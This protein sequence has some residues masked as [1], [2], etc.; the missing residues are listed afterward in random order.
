MA[1]A[2]KRTSRAPAGSS[3][4]GRER[5]PRSPF[6]LAAAAALLFLLGTAEERLFGLVTDESQVLSTAVA[7]A[8]QGEIGIARG[9]RFTVP[10][11]EGDAVSPYGM[12][13][14]LVEVPAVLLAP[15]WESTFGSGTSQ[16]VFVALAA[17]LVWGAGLGAGLLAR[18]LGAGE[19][20]A[21]F[22]LLATAVGSP[23]AAYAGTGYSEPLQALCL[24][25]T[26]LLA[27]R[28]AEDGAPRLAAAA[29]FAAG[30]AV[31]T[32]SVNL[33]IAPLALL[34]LLVGGSSASRDRLRSAAG[35][36]AGAAVPLGAWL[37]FEVA[38]FGRPL[39]SYAGQS[40][41]HSVPDGLWRLLVG[42]NKG[43][44]LYFPLLAAALAGLVALGSRRETRGAAAATAGV[45]G[46]LL[47][48]SS[49]W[50]AWDGTVGWGPRF[51][52]PAVP[53][54][55]A[56]AASW[57]PG[58]RAGRAIVLALGAAGLLVN[59]LGVFE[60]D[61]A[62]GIYLAS[63]GRVP[64]TDDLRRRIPSYYFVPDANGALS[65]PRN[66]VAA[67]DAA[68][69]PIRM[70]AFLLRARLAGANATDIR[71]R[72]GRPPWAES[73]PDAL[74]SL[75]RTGGTLSNA[76][77]YDAYLTEPF[78]WPGVGAVAREASDRRLAR[79]A[80]A[81][82]TALLGQALRNLAIGRPDRA[83]RFATRL[84]ES[85]PFAL[86]AAL[87]AES[88]RTAGR[89][90]EARAFLDGLDRRYAGAGVLA[91]ERALLARD[92][93]DAA[94]A[95]LWMER[96]ARLLPTP[97]VVTAAVLPPERW[98]RGLGSFVTE[99]RAPGP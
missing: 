33:A 64:A 58:F 4:A 31:L 11:P 96:A 54:L 14:A 39:S 68:F 51:L 8:T 62:G 6:A 50:F 40:F 89:A 93:D 41:N 17:F 84:W 37:A 5:R 9:E 92:G 86:H 66:F 74:P 81:H 1:R 87:V 99:E 79:F 75:P 94:E 98:P 88:H 26:A 53:L 46:G 69:S 19:G 67:E 45:F 80:A 59:A 77:L 27:V 23:L 78:R 29:G 3:G 24:V 7:I 83:L 49:A 55:A 34:P 52:L 48:V 70:H 2:K 25:L 42:P 16:T 36:A 61:S 43:L 71:E 38:R 32:K 65:L 90:R 95:A 12:G 20:G 85:V 91:V 21:A 13:L 10:R 72:L 97:A 28:A 63:T 76:T 56:V 18:R 60:A 82:R 73:R 15:W 44:L 57:R 47:L 30:F 22:A 35:A